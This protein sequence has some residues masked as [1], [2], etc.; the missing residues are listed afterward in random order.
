MVSGLIFVGHA[1]QAARQ[2]EFERAEHEKEVRQRDLRHMYG[3]KGH[4]TE[5][6][7][8]MLSQIDH[9]LHQHNLVES[10]RLCPECHRPFVIV[11]VLSIDVDFCRHCKGCWFDPGELGQLTGQASDVPGATAGHRTSQYKCP[12]CGETMWESNFRKPYNLMVDRCPK[13]HG[14]YLEQGE[15]ERALR[16][17]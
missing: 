8:A 1:Q 14:V 13:G 6:E 4:L 3:K 15:L 9:Q 5:D 7:K 16:V 12:I 10:S 17:T 2:A 11:R